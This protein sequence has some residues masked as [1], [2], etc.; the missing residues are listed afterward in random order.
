MLAKRKRNQKMLLRF[1]QG[2]SM[3]KI[4]N[5]KGRGKISVSCMHKIIKQETYFLLHDQKI[6]NLPPL[7]LRD[8]YKEKII[9]LLTTSV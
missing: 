5:S 2:E 9:N 7:V 6:K 8:L 4:K 1:M 3:T